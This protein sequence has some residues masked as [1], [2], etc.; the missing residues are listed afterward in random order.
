MGRAAPPCPLLWETLLRQVLFKSL[1][2]CS[3]WHAESRRYV[4]IKAM[5]VTQILISCTIREVKIPPNE[6]MD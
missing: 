2:M 5:K 1:S 4:V 6:R 3:F